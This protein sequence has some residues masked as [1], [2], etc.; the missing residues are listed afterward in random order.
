LTGVIVEAGMTRSAPQP[1]RVVRSVSSIAR[2]ARWVRRRRL[3]RQR[4]R[5]STRAKKIVRGGDIGRRWF[6]A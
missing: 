4:A 2:L 1:V 5:G 6:S 3:R